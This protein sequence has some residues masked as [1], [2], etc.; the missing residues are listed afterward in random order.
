MIKI[1]QISTTNERYTKY[2]EC[3]GYLTFMNGVAIFESIE[4]TK[5][6]RTSI[7]ETTHGISEGNITIKTLNSKYCYKVIEIKEDE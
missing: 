5:G 1:K 4:H 2:N 3:E 7:I 6:Y